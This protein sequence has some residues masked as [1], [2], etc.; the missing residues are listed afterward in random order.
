[1]FTVRKGYAVNLVDKLIKKKKTKF[2]P[3]LQ[4]GATFNTPK[5][6]TKFISLPYAPVAVPDVSSGG[7]NNSNSIRKN[8][9]YLMYN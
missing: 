6:N 2:R 1:M 9:S 8:Y 5:E 4:N 7:I 3:I